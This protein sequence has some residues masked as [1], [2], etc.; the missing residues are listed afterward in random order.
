MFPI[1]DEV[2]GKCDSIPQ[3]INDNNEL[4][5]FLDAYNA[6]TL[7]PIQ[8][9]KILFGE[10][11]EEYPTQSIYYLY[12]GEICFK[13]QQYSL[14]YESLQKV[15]EV[16]PTFYRAYIEIGDSAYKCGRRY[17]AQKLWEKAMNNTK[18]NWVHQNAHKRIEALKR[19]GQYTVQGK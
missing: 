15:I 1:I 2:K 12:L 7:G 11:S 18:V 14:S 19:H 8:K 3:Y 10:L 17:E 5:K 9:A 16:N 6:M 4:C 13:L